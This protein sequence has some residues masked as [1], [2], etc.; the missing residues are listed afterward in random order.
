MSDNGGFGPMLKLGII[1]ALYAAAACVGL[2]FVYTGTAKVIAVRAQAD[3][4]GALKGLFSDADGF[5]NISGTIKSEDPLVV[6]DSEYA[7]TRGGKVIGVA[8]QASRGSYGGDLKVLVGVGNDGVISG[9]RILEH[10]DT[11]GLGANAASESYYVN[12]AKGLHFYDQFA[13]KPLGD[14]FQVNEDVAAVTAA[15]ITSRAVTDA[16][17]ASGNAAFAWLAGNAG[18]ADP[19]ASQGGSR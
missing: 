5:E 9:V 6:F 7:I 19:A 10:K 14:P 3:L 18:A 12:R 4:E 1:L 16:V 13:G 2:A 15:T 11:P 17:K 8:V